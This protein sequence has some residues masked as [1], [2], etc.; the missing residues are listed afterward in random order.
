MQLLDQ[1]HGTSTQALRTSASLSGRWQLVTKTLPGGKAQV[2]LLHVGGQG[3]FGGL[4]RSWELPRP[5][6]AL[7]FHRQLAQL[8]SD[9][10]E[11]AP[12]SAI[13]ARLPKH[14]AKG[15]DRDARRS[16]FDRR[17]A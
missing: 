13:L 10:A 14:P 2:A 5:D 4:V 9:F 11:E 3:E 8:L 6:Q 7:R 16:R 1:L 12:L 15:Q 17:W